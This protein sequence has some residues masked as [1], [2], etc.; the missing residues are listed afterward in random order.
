MSKVNRTTMM[1]QYL[2]IKANYPDDLL[3]FRMGDFYELFFDDA[4]EAAE[5]LDITLTSRG[6]KS[7]Q[8]VPMCGVPYHSVDSHLHKLIS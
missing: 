6:K 5:L 3:F 2:S 1:D 8:S 4:C 7:G